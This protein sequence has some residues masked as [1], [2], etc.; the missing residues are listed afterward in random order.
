MVRTQKIALIGAQGYDRQAP[1][2]VE[3][4]RWESLRPELN[5]RDYDTIILNL[6]SA[7][8]LEKANW[9][10]FQ[11]ALSFSVA[12]EFLNSQGRIIVLGDPRFSVPKAETKNGEE[13]FLNWTGLAF[14]W[15]DQPGDTVIQ[16]NDYDSRPYSEYL[17]NLK[18]WR[19]SLTSCEIDPASFGRLFDLPRMQQSNIHL[20]ARK[21][22]LCE[23]RYD[24]SLAFVVNVVMEQRTTSRYGPDVQQLNKLG[25]IAFLP[26]TE[27]DEDQAIIVVLRDLCGVESELPEPAWISE[28]LA[29]GQKAIDDEIREIQARLQSLQGDLTLAEKRREDSRDCLK[30]LFER[31]TPLEKAVRGVL[32]SLGAD[33]E[34]SQDVGKEDGWITLQALGRTLEGV[35][36]IKST[37]NDQFGED[38]IR[39]LLDWVNRGIQFRQRRYKGIFIGNSA[40]ERPVQERPWPFSDN[41]KKSAEV[42]QI[43]ALRT[44]DLYLIYVLDTAGKLNREQFWRDVFDRDGLFDVSP[45]LRLVIPKRQDPEG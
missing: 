42:G 19:Y 25:R 31:G 14:C 18:Y 12:S 6:L 27:L 41:W 35:L 23:N 13:P 5:L 26:E 32:R 11:E 16:A 36:E 29:P 21:Q 43:V 8:A 9:G 7:T 20:V 17:K 1:Q 45:Y 4:F 37:R 28:V 10:A 3:C 33:V 22:S 40:V 2:R 24:Q 15:D 44:Q 39:Q 30:L 38:G 34:D